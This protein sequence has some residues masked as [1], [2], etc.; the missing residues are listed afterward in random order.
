MSP[1]LTVAIIAGSVVLACA[2]AVAVLIVAV[3]RSGRARDRAL[4]DYKAAVLGHRKKQ[5]AEFTPEAAEDTS[6]WR[7]Q[8]F[9][10]PHITGR[11]E[12]T[13][14]API[15]VTSERAARETHARLYRD[16]A[17]GMVRVEMERVDLVAEETS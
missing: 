11:D 7:V 1:E 3:I 6:R 16:H 4:A 9:L 17:P 5:P 15:Y 8:G 2:I 14:Y 10:R 13:P 12:D